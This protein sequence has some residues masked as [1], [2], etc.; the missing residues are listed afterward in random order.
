MIVLATFKDTVKVEI[1][2]CHM[3]N[4]AVGFTYKT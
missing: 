3:H 1:Y 2:S 4:S